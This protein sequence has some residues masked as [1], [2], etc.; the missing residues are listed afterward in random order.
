LTKRFKKLTALEAVDWEVSSGHIV[1]LLGSNGAGKSTLLRHMIGLYLPTQGTCETLGCDAATLGPDQLFR[2]GYVHQEGELLDW[3]RVGQ[4]IRYV[5]AYYPLWNDAL[6]EQYMT[7]FEIDQKP[8][9]GTLSPGQRQKVAILLAIGHEPDLLILDEP[10]SALDPLARSAFLDL[11][12][13][14]IQ[15]EGRTIVISSHILSDVE[16][17]IDHVTIMHRARI[18]EDCSF[19]R[20][21]ERYANVLVTALDRDLPDALSITGTRVIERTAR[22]MIIQAEEQALKTLKSRAEQWNASIEIQTL[23]LEQL[24]KRVIDSVNGAHRSKEVA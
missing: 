7:D 19:D 6:V 13:E 4:L 1:G 12:V 16:K 11:L 10:A 20:L 18:I 8:R 24:Y 5:R 3:M 2:I 17:V 22:K 15:K 14:L 23:S 9:V 21:Q